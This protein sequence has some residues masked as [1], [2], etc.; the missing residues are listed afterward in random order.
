[1]RRLM[2][3][4]VVP[5]TAINPASKAESVAAIGGSP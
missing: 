2:Y 1:M 3:L 4:Q 5:L